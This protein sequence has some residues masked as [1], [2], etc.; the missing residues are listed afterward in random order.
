ME[1]KMISRTG[2]CRFCK[3]LRLVELSEDEWLQLI[4]QEDADPEQITGEIATLE[5]NCPDGD[6]YRT[7]KRELKNCEQII[8][9]LFRESYPDIADIFQEAKECV[10]HHAIKKITVTT[11]ESGTASMTKKA[12]GIAVGYSQTR[13]TE[14]ITGQC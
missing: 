3:Q 7:E 2:M 10:H 8:E 4:Q 12:Q 14:I 5:C 9:D 11:N 1:T 13:K 6:S